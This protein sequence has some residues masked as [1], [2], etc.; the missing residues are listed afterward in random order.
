[1]GFNC[2]L[3][4]KDLE[5]G[6]LLIDYN[7]SW[8]QKRRPNHTVEVGGSRRKEDLLYQGL[9]GPNGLIGVKRSD[10][11]LRSRPVLVGYYKFFEHK[12]ED[13]TT[14]DVEGRGGCVIC[15]NF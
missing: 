12:K 5:T 8:T 9:E 4:A 11:N 14:H 10:M 3:I 6:C 7:Q 15:Q 13:P 2:Q 1:M